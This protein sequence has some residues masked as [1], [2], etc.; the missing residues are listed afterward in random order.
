MFRLGCQT[1]CFLLIAT[2]AARGAAQTASGDNPPLPR[3]TPQPSPVDEPQT[4]VGSAPS[5]NGYPTGQEQPPD[6]TLLDFFSTGWD[7]EWTKRERATGTPDFALMRVQTNFM[8]REF[9]MDFVDPRNINSG[10]YLN[11][12][13][14]DALIAWGFDRRL[15]VEV[16][17]AYQ[18]NDLRAGGDINGGTP[19]LVGRLQ[20]VDTESSSY[21]FNFKATAPNVGIGQTQSTVS[22]GLAGFE[23]LAYWFHL[24]RVGLYY[25]FLFD[26]LW[27]PLPEAGAAHTD[28][29]Y[30]IT[31]AKTILPPDAP[32]VGNLTFFLEN[33]AQSNMDGEHP[34]RTYVTMTPGFRFNLGLWTDA[35][36]G[37]DNSILVGCDIPVSDYRPWEVTPRVTYIKNF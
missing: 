35:K 24:D 23:D 27:G 29:Q 10:K 22:Y 18:W 25:S 37:K 33:F 13:N 7:E 31:L 17:G 16:Y 15:M 9:R 2:F 6:L 32:L 12:P 19:T 30:D 20:L 26:S 3:S 1:V 21:S 28:V 5:G 4:V 14:V 11:E 34:G 8:E 36:L